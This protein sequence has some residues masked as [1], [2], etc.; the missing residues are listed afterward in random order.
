M[1]NRKPKLY[2]PDY[3]GYMT[4][5]RNIFDRAE[6]IGQADCLM[7]TGGEDVDPRTYGERPGSHT[8]FTPARDVYELDAFKKAQAKKIPIIGICRGAQLLCAIAGGSLVQH[9]TGHHRHHPISTQDGRTLSMSSLHHQMMRPEKTNHVLIAWAS[10]SLSDRYLGQDD[11]ELY[12]HEFVPN[13]WGIG[14][15]KSAHVEPEI[16]Y[17]KD[18][19][20]L[21]IQGH[22]EMMPHDHPTVD[23]CRNLVKEY[24]LE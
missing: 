7:L 10:P 21:G 13:G 19:K 3:W 20:G 18:I 16:V 22:P 23:Y 24:L 4:P 17:F 14:A 2:I 5:F 12:G 8:Y 15:T 9:A 11:E 1:F 6:S